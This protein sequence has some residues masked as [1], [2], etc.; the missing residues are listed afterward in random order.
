MAAEPSD[1][2]CRQHRSM[3]CI[4]W[5]QARRARTSGDD[6]LLGETLLALHE[7]ERASDSFAAALE[8]EPENPAAV[9]WLLPAYKQLANDC[10]ARLSDSFPDSWR[11]HK[12]QAELYLSRGQN[13]QAIEEFQPALR[14]NPDD[15]E[16]HQALGDLYLEKKLL[17]EA[18]VELEK[19]LRIDP[20]A[21]RTLYLV[22]WL[23]VAERKPAEGIPYFQTPLRRD[24]RLLEARAMLGRAYLHLGKAQLAVPELE[25]ASA[26]DHYGDVHFLLS[27]AYL[28]VGK[29][30][31]ARRALARSQ[32]LRKASEAGD[33]ERLA[34]A[35][36]DER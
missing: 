27:Q 18:R 1:E 9:Y 17:S 34:R 13:A 15:P 35:Y 36:E 33:Q 12:M 6:L 22:G 2:A 24:P 26:L 25:K 10:F 3:E 4:N 19:A 16:I 29:A 20:A 8:R 32:D 23:H 11:I 28:K 14:K 21:P 31:L 7:D 5:L 30:E